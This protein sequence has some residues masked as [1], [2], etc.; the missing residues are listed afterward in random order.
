MVRAM[1]NSSHYYRHSFK[2]QKTNPEGYAVTNKDG[3]TIK[4]VDREEFSKNNFANSEERFG[5]K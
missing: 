4:L 3:E 2:G 5:K 1:N